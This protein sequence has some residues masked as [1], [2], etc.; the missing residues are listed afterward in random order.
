[1]KGKDQRN[2]I[3]VLSG[4]RNFLS[5]SLPFPLTNSLPPTISPSGSTFHTQSSPFIRFHH[6]HTLVF[7]TSSLGY[8]LYLP[9]LRQT[10]LPLNISTPGS[11]Y[12]LL[13]F[14][15]FPS[16]FLPAISPP[17]H[18]S[19]ERST[20]NVISHFLLQMLPACSV[21]AAVFLF[22]QYLDCLS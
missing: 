1:M 6:L 5:R 17:H 16:S 13:V 3:T 12:N 7:A 18:Q 14:A 8:S 19:E 9:P 4:R 20:Q 21:P 11:T 22:D 10:H 2:S 15:A